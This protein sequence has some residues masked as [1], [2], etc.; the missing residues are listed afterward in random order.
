MRSRGSNSADAQRATSQTAPR[1]RACSLGTQDL[2]ARER[3]TNVP[4]NPMCR[5]SLMVRR[6]PVLLSCLADSGG[7]Y[8]RPSQLVAFGAAS[9]CTG[10]EQV[11]GDMGGRRQCQWPGGSCVAPCST[12]RSA[13]A[14]VRGDRGGASTHGVL[15]KQC[16]IDT[17]SAPAR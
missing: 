9:V 15:S 8:N 5:Q 16:L 13:H 12:L 1:K 3:P 11:G 17:A 14:W 4:L 10:V 6:V 7:K 2:A